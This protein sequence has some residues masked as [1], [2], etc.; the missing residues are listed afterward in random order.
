MAEKSALAERL[1]R[2]TGSRELAASISWAL[3]IWQP[4]SSLRI[5]GWNMP[6]FRPRKGQGERA[7]LVACNGPSGAEDPTPVRPSLASSAKMRSRSA[8]WA[9]RAS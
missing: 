8:M 4:T 3:D 9:L 7:S 1:L 6:P 2:A 5:D